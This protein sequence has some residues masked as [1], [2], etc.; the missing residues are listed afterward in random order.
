MPFA[1]AFNTPLPSRGRMFYT[2]IEITRK[3]PQRRQTLTEQSLDFEKAWQTKLQ[4][5]LHEHTCAHPG[6]GWIEGGDVLSSTS[7]RGQVIAWTRD[8]LEKMEA[9]LACDVCRDVLT[10]CA[11]QYPREQLQD[12]RQCYQQS[13]SY[14][15]AHQML[16]SR[17]E[18]FLRRTLHLSDQASEEII[19]L[20]WG[21]AGILQGKTIIATKIP[22]SGNLAAYFREIEPTTKR[23]LYCHCPRVRETIAL[24]ETLPALYCY[25][26]A[27]FYQGIWEEIL[28][29]PVKVEVLHSVLAGDDTCTIA[30]YLH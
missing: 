6:T 18:E 11:C 17:F 1:E 27:G 20:G 22:K 26:G 9:R 4:R 30:V 5:A 10:S 14:Q 12:V 16:Q 13:G 24:G 7:D 21:L 29:A 19:R 28:Q 2:T 15:L 25:C 8:L 3:N 23:E